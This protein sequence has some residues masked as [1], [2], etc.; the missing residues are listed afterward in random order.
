MSLHSDQWAALFFSAGLSTFIFLIFKW[1]SKRN[2]N[3]A[4]AIVWNYITC[5]WLGSLLS[6]KTPVFTL[7]S[8]QTPGFLP[9]VSLGV[10]FMGTFL[11]MGRATAKSGAALSAVASKMSVTIPVLFALFVFLE[12]IKPIGYAGVI[13]AILAVFLISYQPQSKTVFDRSLLWVFLGS[14]LVDTGMNLVKHAEYG[15]WS[16]LQFAVLTFTGA[17]ITGI[18]YTYFTKAFKALWKLES[19]IWGSFL[20][21]INL[22]SIFAIYNALDVFESKTAV[23]FTLNNVTVV[24]MTF[25]LGLILGERFSKRSMLGLLLAIL[26]ILLLS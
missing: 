24:L 25:L 2:V 18:T 14:G 5:V 3:L 13:L 19:F 15:S 6:Y 8:I 1:I 9:I 23:F 10:L 26:A 16:N 22:F 20:G 21:V 7:S 4:S 12:Q 11:L 17:A